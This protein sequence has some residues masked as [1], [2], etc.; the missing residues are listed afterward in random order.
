M[1]TDA[2][3]SA[4]SVFF[5]QSPPF[6]DFQRTMQETQGRNIAQTLFGVFDIPMDN[7]IRTLLDAVEPEA[8][9]PLFDFV[10]DG[11]QRTGVIDAFRTT[12]SRL[13]LAFDGT[14]YFSSNNI[15]CPCCSSKTHSNGKVSYSH[16]VVTPGVIKSTV[17]QC[18]IESL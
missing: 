1:M 13:L 17:F 9:Y 8:V 6:L 11:F 16:T 5:M 7:H 10:F 4:F 2:G 15:H 12:E 3:L 14:D 18:I